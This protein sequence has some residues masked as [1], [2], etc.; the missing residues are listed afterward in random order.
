MPFKFDPN[1]DL[2]SQVER[3]LGKLRKACENRVNS[4]IKMALALREAKEQEAQERALVE[5]EAAAEE[6][7]GEEARRQ[8]KKRLQE[9]ETEEDIDLSLN[10]GDEVEIVVTG[11][12]N[13]Y[14][15]GF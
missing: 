5:R 13:V 7:R 15:D 4:A 14:R 3:A 8:R 11:G 9:D 10:I 6:Q 2:A 12:G 1:L